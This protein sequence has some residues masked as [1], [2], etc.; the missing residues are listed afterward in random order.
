MKRKI[1]KQGHNTLTMTLPSEWVKKLNLKAGDEIDV[2]ENENSLVLNGFERIKEKSAVIDIKGFTVPL[3]WRFFQGAY[4]AGCDEIKIVFDENTKLYED[5]YHYYTTQFDYA[6]LGEQ[7]PEKL[8]LVAIQSLVDRFVGIEIIE[9]GKNYILIKEM[10]EVSAKEFDN[11]LRRIFLVVFQLFDRIMEAI[12]KNE[13]GSIALCKDMHTIDLNIDRFVDYCARILNKINTS[14]PEKNKSL[15]FSTLYL[16]ELLGDEFKYIG[17]HLA[18]SKKSIQEVL[19]LAE[20]V[21]E[22]FDIYYKLFYKFERE[23]AIEFGE[24]DKSVYEE[25]YRFKGRVGQGRS[26]ARHLMMISKFTLALAELRIE[27]EY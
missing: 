6:E 3:L 11:S 26:I 19:P 1:I 8:I 23:K 20:K 5:P 10:G 4:R 13:I 17:K 14:F 22:H 12:E 16:L 15:L 24:N 2:H 21:R 25:H 7:K 9:H 27:M 18:I